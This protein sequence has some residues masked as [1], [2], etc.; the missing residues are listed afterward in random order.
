MK[1]TVTRIFCLKKGL[2]FMSF[3][4]KFKQKFLGVTPPE[5]PL[6]RRPWASNQALITASPGSKS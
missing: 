4:D 5:P 3:K 1:Y 2:K 6:K